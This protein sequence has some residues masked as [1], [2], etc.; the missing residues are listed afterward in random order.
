MKWWALVFG[1]RGV[2][3]G[4]V[5]IQGYDHNEALDTADRLGLVPDL[6]IHERIMIAV[7]EWRLAAP[8]PDSYTH[9]LL[10]ELEWRALERVTEDA[11]AGGV[12]VL[13]VARLVG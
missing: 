7:F 6:G 8:P 13:A 5:L 3:L 12:Q 10:S 4:T 9:R 1:K 2:L 11:Y